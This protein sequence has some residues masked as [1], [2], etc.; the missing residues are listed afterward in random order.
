MHPSKARGGLVH[1]PGGSP[2]WIFT[3]RFLRKDGIA[4]ESREVALEIAREVLEIKRDLVRLSRLRCTSDHLRQLGKSQRDGEFVRMNEC[5]P[6]LREKL[7]AWRNADF[8]R[9]RQN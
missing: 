8:V 2:L 7:C 5:R 3:M 9:L 6:L 1:V 4:F